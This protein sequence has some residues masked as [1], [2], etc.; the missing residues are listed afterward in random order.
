M[1]DEL[2]GVGFE[3]VSLF[4]EDLEYTRGKLL[5][6]GKVIDLC[7]QKFD[8]DISWEYP[9][10]PDADSARKYVKALRE[11]NVIGVNS[12]ASTY[13]IESKIVLA[14]FWDKCFE[15]YF[16]QEEIALSRSITAR[17][18]LLCRQGNEGIK[19][20]K[21][22]KDSLVLKKSLDTRGRSVMLGR[23]TPQAIWDKTLEDNRFNPKQSYVVQTYQGHE[24]YSD[25]NKQA[26]YISHAYFIVAG[27]PVGMFTRL[28][29]SPVTNVGKCGRTGIAFGI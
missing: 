7:Y 21:A 17:T 16:T 2:T 14:L 28:S 3:A 18:E 25:I 1:I 19:R 29:S 22:E 12:F 11:R 13:L 6:H 24:Q 8:D 23:D 26:R 5:G 15:K 4:V 9:F 20:F 10:T 27:E